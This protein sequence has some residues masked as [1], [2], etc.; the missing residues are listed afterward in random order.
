[1]FGVHRAQINA[2]DRRQKLDNDPDDD[3]EQDGFGKEFFP[4]L[5]ANNGLREDDRAKHPR[6]SPKPGASL[7]GG[8]DV[9][10]SH[11]GRGYQADN[12]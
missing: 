2:Q 9:V 1:M 4:R 3:I 8:V 10:L 5:D 12:G 6:L 11:R 7:I